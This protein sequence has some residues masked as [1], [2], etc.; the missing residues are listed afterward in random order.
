MATK[1]KSRRSFFLLAACRWP[2]NSSMTHPFLWNISAYMNINISTVSDSDE[3]PRTNL[4]MLGSHTSDSLLPPIV[5]V[6]EFLE[7]FSCALIR[8]VS[9]QPGP[10]F[11]TASRMGLNPRHINPTRVA[12]QPRPMAL[13]IGMIA[14]VAPAPTQ[15]LTRL[16]AADAVPG[17]SGYRSTTRILRIVKAEAAL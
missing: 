6:L 10:H 15:H 5:Y 3:V 7:A 12:D 13:I 2:R 16:L 11:M 1:S 9:L 14:T 17:P 4:C 8:F